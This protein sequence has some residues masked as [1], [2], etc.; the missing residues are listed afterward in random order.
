MQNF[1]ELVLETKEQPNDEL[2]YY[3]VS[4][5]YGKFDELAPNFN[6]LPVDFSNYSR[7]LF[8]CII[9]EMKNKIPQIIA[10]IMVLPEAYDKCLE[11][12]KN[13]LII[14]EL[15]TSNLKYCDYISRTNT[16]ETTEKLSIRDIT[17][18]NDIT[19]KL[20]KIIELKSCIATVNPFITDEDNQI[21]LGEV[22]CTIDLNVSDI[23]YTVK[24]NNIENMCNKLI[25]MISEIDNRWKTKCSECK[26]LKKVNECY[27][28]GNNLKFKPENVNITI[29]EGYI[30][31]PCTV[32]KYLNKLPGILEDITII[33]GRLSY[34][35]YNQIVEYEKENY[36]L[37]TVAN[38]DSDEPG[39]NLK[40]VTFD[41]ASSN[42][43]PS[44]DE[45]VGDPKTEEENPT[46]KSKDPTQSKG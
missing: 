38:N 22:K 29:S 40:L 8:N 46:L 20:N 36:E 9:R 10:E 12:F 18:Y 27:N 6:F 43:N 34:N 15:L 33:C 24:C 32:V 42:G 26:R 11:A 39:S 5:D 17:L 31:I 35:K 25:P 23:K 13:S 19:L 41:Q 44:W 21:I 1:S 7:D 4:R 28:F 45:F 14:G 30:D 3:S 2:R 37:A 16:N